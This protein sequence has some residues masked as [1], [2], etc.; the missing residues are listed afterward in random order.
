MNTTTLIVVILGVVILLFILKQFFKIVKGIITLG[1][2]AVLIFFAYSTRSVWVP[3]I[4]ESIT[5]KIEL[6]SAVVND[7]K[8]MGDSL[9]I[10]TKLDSL[11]KEGKEFLVKKALEK[12]AD[13][14]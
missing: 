14:K 10:K 11:G 9:K 13:E 1:I 8:N 6:D 4:P 3:M 7:L 12:M 5:S 2:I